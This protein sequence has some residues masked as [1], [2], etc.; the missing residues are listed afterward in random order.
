LPL[1]GAKG[2][3][4]A[5]LFYVAYTL[6]GGVQRPITFVFNG[7][8][9]AASAF[10]HLG[11]LGPR[12]VNFVENGSAPV[13]PVQLS[14]N[15]DSW[16]QFTDLVFIDPAGTG[17]SRPTATGEE[18]E[19]AFWGV[20]KDADALAAFIALYLARNERV[21][22]PL[23][24]AGES[25]G[26]FR[27]GLLCDRV[28]RMGYNLKGAVLI[29]PALEF[30]MLRGNNYS[31]MPLALVL[32]SLT[33]AHAELKT[34]PDANLDVA[35]DAETFARTK[36]LLHLAAGLQHDDAIIA[37]LVNFTG[38]EADL[39]SRHHGRVPASLFLREYQRQNDRALS[40]YDATV[41]VPLPKPSDNEHFDPLLDGAVSVMQPAMVQ[42]V[43]Q[44]LGY[45][46]DLPY[47]L[48]NREVSRQWDFG[49]KLGHQGYAGSLD[50]LE[51]AR[52]RYPGLK[53]LVAHGYTD[54]VTP[55]GVSQ[56]LIG[57]LRPIDTAAPVA[58]KV[59]RG[60][61][62]MYLRPAS[63]RQLKDDA[64]EFYA[65]ASAAP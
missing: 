43:R 48:L 50:E 27:A 40:A 49:G 57:Q 64:R 42:Y 5:K 41:S 1:P 16:L 3:T 18:A 55:Y 61:H 23:F 35:R 2:E 12:V 38:L 14:D 24:L 65:S 63:R 53:I 19:R 47:R 20:A 62:M 44:E 10:L 17:Y 39:I 28:L 9:G 56:F 29:S 7:G 37:A 36:Y 32:P 15:P 6:D 58:L 52:T 31:I 34:G 26:G 46:S 8:P 59:Y 54:L 21:L 13:R 51:K 22:S 30:S 4:A 60:G 11:A 25:Y 45:R 33:A